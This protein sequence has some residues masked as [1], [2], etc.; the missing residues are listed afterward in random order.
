[1][2]MMLSMIQTP[3][4]ALEN[5]VITLSPYKIHPHHAWDHDLLLR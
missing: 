4:A 5:V 3:R 1:M 2:S